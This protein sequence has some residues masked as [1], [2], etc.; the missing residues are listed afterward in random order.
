MIAAYDAPR[1]WMMSLTISA[2]GNYMTQLYPV[3]AKFGTLAVKSTRISET[4]HQPRTPIGFRTDPSFTFTTH[5]ACPIHT[6]H[7]AS[8]AR[9]KFESEYRQVLKP[10]A[11]IYICINVPASS[12]IIRL[13]LIR[14][15]HHT[16]YTSLLIQGGPAHKDRLQKTKQ[17]SFSDS[18]MNSVANSGRSIEKIELCCPHSNT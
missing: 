13:P 11:Y 12:T 4:S 9:I 6:L 16:W 10:F 7:F 15:R 18:S 5:P 14:R 8:F 17:E 3:F 1:L 2:N